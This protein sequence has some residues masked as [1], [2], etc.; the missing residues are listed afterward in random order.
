MEQL[1]SIVEKTSLPGEEIA[2]RTGQI[3][4]AL[5]AESRNLGV[6]NFISIAPIDVERMFQR[7]DE[8]FFAGQIQ[9]ALGATPLT[10][11]F[12]KRMTSAGGK[13]TSFRDRRQ[14]GR[15]FELTFSSTILFA[16]FRDAP[17]EPLTSSGIVCRD[18]LEA[19]QRV[20]EHELIHL[21]EMMIWDRSSCD[22]PR[23]RQICQRMFGHTEH[24]HRLITPR[25]RA[26]VTFGIQP[27]D[28]VHFHFEGAHHTGIVNRITRRATVLVEDPA[29]E[30]Y[31]NGR[32]YKKFYV[33][34]Q[35][36]R[37]ADR[38]S[39]A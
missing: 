20:M 38:H 10:F 22:R 2:R 27:G 9:R 14:G 8:A 21:V 31:T 3:H 11:R 6:G 35:M 16:C 26:R 39:P 7:Y 37:P 33:P 12:S 28:Q 18:R 23:F 5:L 30:R 19:L 17:D 25:E 15:R 36:L 34:L 4:Q 1:L 29:G 32:H 13:T 24:R